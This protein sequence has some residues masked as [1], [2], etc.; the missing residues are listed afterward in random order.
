MSTKT[1]IVGNAVVIT[2]SLKADEILKVKKFTKSGLKL[3]DEKGNEIFSIDYIPGR[4]SSISEYGVVYAE[5]NAE[6]YAQVTLLMDETV[7]AEDRMDVLL[8]NYAIALGNLNTLETY[9]REA[10]TELTATVEG[11]KNNIEI[12]D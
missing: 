5:T 9:I 8:D 2:S 1:K 6:G 7:K 4:N 10:A 12:V 3:R 11:I